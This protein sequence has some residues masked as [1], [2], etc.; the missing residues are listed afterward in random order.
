[1]AATKDCGACKK[2]RNKSSELIISGVTSTIC[3]NL[4]NNKGIALDD[5]AGDC[6]DLDQMNDC[7]VGNM[8]DELNA[9]E[10]CDWKRYMRKFVRNLWNMLRAMICAICGIWTTLDKHECEISYLFE[11]DS[12]KVG[13]E[14]SDGSY[15]VAGKGITFLE[16][17]GG[18]PG[19]A[20]VYLTYIGG[21]LLRGG[22]SIN[23]YK[24]DFTEPNNTKCYNFD[25][26]GD[27]SNHTYNRKGNNV[28]TTTGNT[29]NGN[30]LLYEIRMKLS[31]YPTIKQL[32]GGV[33]QEA[34][35]GGFHV[36][37]SVFTEG[38]YAYGQ[39]GRCNEDGTS[40][41][42]GTSANPDMSSKGHIV[43]DGWVYWQVRV[44]YIDT[45]L[46]GNQNG[47]QRTPRYWGGIR[48]KRS[49]IEC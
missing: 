42:N 40:R 12:F 47:S 21:A 43:P 45:M 17:A 36:N 35:M 26:D 7:L 6:T 15:V 30:E 31:Q 38:E 20:D 23:V 27:G 29:T 3:T 34:N 22:G 11:G 13:E 4:K 24:N 48:F 19:K 49:G 25:D 32:Y 18:D 44:S 46:S 10:V 2:L 9:Y 37:I 28:W 5:G 39:H 41:N 14:P 8:E 1:M 16:A 33:G